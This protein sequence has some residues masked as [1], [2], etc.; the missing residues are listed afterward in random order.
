MKKFHSWLTTFEIPDTIYDYLKDINFDYS[1]GRKD[2][3]DSL[4]LFFKYTPLSWIQ[5]ANR[6]KNVTDFLD[7][8]DKYLKLFD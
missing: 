8:Y 6:R 4:F 3:S 2:F 7:K 1:V 5:Q